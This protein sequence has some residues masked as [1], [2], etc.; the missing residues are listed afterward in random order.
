MKQKTFLFAAL[1]AAFLS[2]ASFSA[3]QVTIG[4]SD[5]PKAGTI[6]DLNSSS[7]DKGGL[8][9]SNVSIT[10]LNAIPYDVSADVFP[11]I[12]ASNHDTKKGD[13]AGMMVYSTN[14]CL[15]PNGDGLY[16]WDGN[17]WNYIGGSDGLA[18]CIEIQTP[19]QLPVYFMTYN[20]GADPTLNT[21]K[22]QMQYMMT[23]NMNE[24]ISAICGDLYQW[25][26]IADGHEKRDAVPYGGNNTTTNINPIGSTFL[27]AISGQIEDDTYPSYDKMAEDQKYGHFIKSNSAAGFD[28]RDPKMDNLWGNG[29]G[30]EPQDDPDGGILYNGKYYHNTNWDIPENNPCPAGFRVPTIDEWERLLIAD[31]DPS[32]PNKDQYVD[33]TSVQAQTREVTGFSVA[34]WKGSVVHTSHGLTWVRV[35]CS[36]SGC[37]LES[38]PGMQ[39]SDRD[40]AGYV[41]Y[42][43][44]DWN[45]ADPKYTNSDGSYDIDGTSALHED[46]APEALMFLPAAGWRAASNGEAVTPGCSKP[47]PC[48]QG[49]SVN[50]YYWSSTVAGN[51]PAGGFNTGDKYV[52][53][54]NMHST[55]LSSSQ[56]A[57]R[58]AGHSVR[59]V[60]K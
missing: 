44:T 11:G 31:A 28:W 10:N 27:N 1:T 60:R 21:P 17:K 22:K 18:S 40:P 23:H 20:L 36:S 39:L 19:G 2:V 54:F 32:I 29:E 53:V 8:L 46:D 4:G 12:E 38:W 16:V 9:L 14:E 34:D 51:L 30:T 43:T 24:F 49:V 26:R 3:A 59:C 41:L 52:R 37:R 25:G 35:L 45:A 58:A 42:R 13:L 48:S 55:L 57:I 33:I 7:G 6:L 5:L 50:G 15:H 56:L 47:N